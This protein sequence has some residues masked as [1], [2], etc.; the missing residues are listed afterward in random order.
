MPHTLSVP[1]TL[2]LHNPASIPPSLGEHKVFQITNCIQH[3][4]PLIKAI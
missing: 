3:G 1:Y 4:S 2:G